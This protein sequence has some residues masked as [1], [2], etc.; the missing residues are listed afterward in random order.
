MARLARH[1]GT[2]S[3]GALPIIVPA[4]APDGSFPA[5]TLLPGYGMSGAFGE[6]LVS[7][8]P[9]NPLTPLLIGAPWAGPG[10]PAPVAVSLPNDPGLV[11]QTFYFQGLLLDPTS[12]VRFGLADA[13]LMT[14]GS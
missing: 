13:V 2:Q 6:L 4:T 5:G 14:V 1:V 11:G 9:P 10:N 12:T 3:A 8:S 7:L